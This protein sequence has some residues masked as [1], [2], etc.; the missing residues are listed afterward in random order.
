MPS[1]VIML[2]ILGGVFSL[3]AAALDMEWFMT[4]YRAAV[5]VRILGRTGARLFYALLG[6]FLIALGLAATFGVIPPR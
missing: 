6:L 3:M 1:W 4:N 5:F 2:S